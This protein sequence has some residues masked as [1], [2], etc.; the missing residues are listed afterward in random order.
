[1]SYDPIAS[2][3][4]NVKH[5]IFLLE[6]FIPAVDEPTKSQMKEKLEELKQE[7]SVA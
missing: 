2:K 1:M 4:T 6:M 3:E 5:E 7:V